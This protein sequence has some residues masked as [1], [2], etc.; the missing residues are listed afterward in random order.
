MMVP[1][2]ETCFRIMDTYGM[3]ENIVAHSVVV[4]RAASLLAT[5]LRDAGIRISV[6]RV[7]AGALL[8]DIGKTLSLTT[9]EDHSRVG[10]RICMENHLHE[11]ADIVG[12]H[13]RMTDYHL[14]DGYSEKEIVFY[15]DKRV[16]HD[17]VVTLEDR[18]SYVLERYAKDRPELRRA[19]RK[20][21]ELCARVEKKLFRRLP[22]GP[23]S[24]ARRTLSDDPLLRQRLDAARKAVRGRPERG[25]VRV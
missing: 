13:V 25:A 7:T 20:N 16:N 23:E 10:R 18:L 12:E 8:H 1:S 2:I 21:F 5:G 17:R 22:F 3:L 4:T 9:G 19:I 15:A 6:P 11:I 24:L 14:D